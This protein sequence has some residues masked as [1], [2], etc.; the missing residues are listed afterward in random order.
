MDAILTTEEKY[1]SSVSHDLTTKRQAIIESIGNESEMSDF[2][3]EESK[4]ENMKAIESFNSLLYIPKTQVGDPE[5]VVDLLKDI[6]IN[7]RS[8][9]TKMVSFKAP[10][11]KMTGYMPILRKLTQGKC[12]LDL[13][14]KGYN[15]INPS[16]V[17]NL[18]F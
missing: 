6:G 17:A 13:N 9:I 4:M 7:D 2:T 8:Q 15:T 3:T 12:T 1:I 14:F 10:I 5:V 18:N 11:R 16:D